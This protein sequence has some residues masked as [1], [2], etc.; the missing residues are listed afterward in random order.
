[1]KF[2]WKTHQFQYEKQYEVS[3]KKKLDWVYFSQIMHT[4]LIYNFE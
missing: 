1:M 3:H 4:L 2:V